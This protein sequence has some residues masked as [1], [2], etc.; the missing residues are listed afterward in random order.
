L[1]AIR[2][3]LPSARESDPWGWNFGSAIPPSYWAYGRLRALLTLNVAAALQPRRVLEVAAGDAALSA[4]LQIQGSEVTVNDLRGDLLRSCIQN[5]TNSEVFRILEGN[6]LEI[7]ANVT[8]KFDLVIAGELIEHVADP[9]ALLKKLKSFLAAEGHVLLTTPNGAY[10]R[11][12]LPTYTEVHDHQSLLER[13][14][15]PDADGHLYLLTLSELQQLCKA[16]GLELEFFMVWGTPFIS[17]E[18]GFRFF[19][20]FLPRSICFA[21]EKLAQRLPD[22]V[23][24]RLGNSLILVLRSV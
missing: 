22:S 8:G 19:G 10:F 12:R 13:Q 7:D 16:A 18:S 15:K 23:E 24:Q 5:F 14:F 2:P 1:S 4:C 17:G 3:L 11:N 6:V 9:V 20:K 21:L